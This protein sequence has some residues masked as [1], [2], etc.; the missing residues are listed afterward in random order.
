MS[1]TSVS[2]DLT[3]AEKVLANMQAALRVGSREGVVQM[4]REIAG[5][6]A[7]TTKTARAARTIVKRKP[8]TPV[9]ENVWYAKRNRKGLDGYI[10][11]VAF[12]KADA[13]RDDRAQIKQRG[14]AKSAW[15][16]VLSGVGG[17]PLSGAKKGRNVRKN[18]RYY[19]VRD[20]RNAFDPAIFLHSKLDY[21]SDALKTTG[22]RARI[23][24]IGQRAANRFKRR[25]EKKALRAGVSL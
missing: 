18:P 10:G 5:A 9:E 21:A 25:M 13:R 3:E 11:I 12:D 20:H 24:N 16:W 8:G 23:D 22:K 17:R 15:Y 19:N 4:S 6:M 2:I 14:L 7:A 1:N